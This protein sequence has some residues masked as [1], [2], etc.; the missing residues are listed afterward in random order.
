MLAVDYE[1]GMAMMEEQE[2]S[3]HEAFFQDVLEIARRHKIMN[4]E[5]MRTEYAKVG[6]AVYLRAERGGARKPQFAAAAGV[7]RGR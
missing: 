5:K 1:K 2:Y 3:E 6:R 4:P 7:W